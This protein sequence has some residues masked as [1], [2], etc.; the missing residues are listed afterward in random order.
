MKCIIILSG[1]SSGSSACQN[2]L[3]SFPHVRHVAKTRHFENETLYWTKSASL[4][5]LPQVPMVDSEVP[6]SR[7]RA[8]RELTR[9]LKDNV[10][11]YGLPEDDRELVFGGW[12]ALCRQFGPVFVEKSPHHL[13]QWSALQ[14][15][16][17][18]V[19]CLP[20]VE[21]QFVGLV[22][23]PMDTF[24]S[25]WKRRRTPPG[26]SEKEWLCAYR[27]LER[28]AA[29]AGKKIL[30]TKY[31]RMIADPDSLASFFGLRG[32]EE[33]ERQ[34]PS[35]H[36]RSL[37]KWKA[38][39]WYGFILSPQAM[40]LAASYSY[41]EEE[42]ANRPS[43]MWPLCLHVARA[44]RLFLQPARGVAQQFLKTRLSYSRSGRG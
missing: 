24:Y 30:V 44:W 41:G 17:E 9:L 5:G 6:F 3:T 29:A 8:R 15:I 32:A 19:D 7:S 21:F 4:L 36:S 2:F 16:L 20:E 38:D 22:R 39:S 27:N 13:H 33:K 18:A 42:L 11:S 37:S 43:L 14:L 25:A 28:F 1:K 31:E 40:G 12:A 23:N 35:L 26:R 10:P 34:R